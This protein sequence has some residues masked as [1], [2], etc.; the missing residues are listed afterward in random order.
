MSV[1]PEERA[2]RLARLQASSDAYVN[3]V[4]AEEL[5]SPYDEEQA[6]NLVSEALSMNSEVS[7]KEPQTLE[8]RIQKQAEY[9]RAAEQYLLEQLRNGNIVLPNQDEEAGYTVYGDNGAT[10]QTGT[11]IIPSQNQGQYIDGIYVPP[12]PAGSTVEY[13]VNQNGQTEVEIN[14]PQDENGMSPAMKM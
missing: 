6:V 7:I 9:N 13:H 1:T 5:Q 4:R 2:A 3:Q 8:E 12:T 14:L 10:S 11:P